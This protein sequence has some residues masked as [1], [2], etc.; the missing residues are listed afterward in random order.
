[1]RKIGLKPTKSSGSGWIEK[2]DGENDFILAQLK[3]TDAESIKVNMFDI[4][5][6]EYHANVSKK[7]PLFVLH[8][9]SDDSLFFV[10]RPEHLKDIY[11][12]LEVEES[13]SDVKSGPQNSEVNGLIDHI[14]EDI[15]KTKPT[16]PKK[17]IKS[18]GRDK[19]WKLK[20]KEYNKRK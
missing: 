4:E 5:K 10:L 19:Y 20:E 16:K 7:I 1:M 14:M 8:F 6:L 12:Y 9:L 2:E 17:I 13:L 18:S 15:G 11:N 3:S